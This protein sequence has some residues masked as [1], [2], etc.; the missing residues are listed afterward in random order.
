MANTIDQ[1]QELGTVLFKYRSM[2]TPTE[3]GY[4]L[5]IF[6]NHQL[7]CCAPVLFNDPF[8]CKAEISF[9]A[10]IEVKNRRAIEQLMKKNPGMPKREA[11]KRALMLW[12]ELEQK[13]GKDFL[14]WLDNDTGVIS[15][16]EVNNDILMWSHY[17]GGHNGLC[18]EF[19]CNND[20]CIDFFAS[21]LRV[22]Y[23]KNLP[24]INFY[25]TP[26]EEKLKAFILTK[27]DHWSYEK[28]WR[29]IIP[30]NTKYI[31]LPPRVISAIYFGCKISEE[32]RNEILR[33]VGLTS[34]YSNIRLF[35][36]KQLSSAYGLDFELINQ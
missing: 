5:D 33:C 3:R 27:S 11:R 25:T 14:R 17:A 16:S 19:R 8:E 21:I 4:T 26:E 30:D 7:Y 29:I 35:Q 12:K 6:N 15:F 28:E 32:N 23:Q 34:E 31:P 36:A 18:I 9:D 24:S 2:A 22:H 13:N 20:Y 1:S 10:R